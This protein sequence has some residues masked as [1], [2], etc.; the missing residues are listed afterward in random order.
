MSRRPPLVGADALF[1]DPK[2]FVRDDV[3]RAMAERS[4][5]GDG[6][7]LGGNVLGHHAACFGFHP[8][9]SRQPEHTKCNKILRL[10]AHLNSLQAQLKPW[11]EHFE[12]PQ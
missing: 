1:D 7:S 10:H 4:D 3:W 11:I 2:G 9:A 8:S 6:L 12:S 5:R